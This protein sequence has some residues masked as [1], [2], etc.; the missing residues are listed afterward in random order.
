MKPLKSNK[1]RKSAQGKDCTLRVP[2]ACCFDP[3]YTSLNH[4]TTKK[5]SS[6]GGKVNDTF[7][8]YGCTP[9]HDII[10]RRV[11][12]NFTDGELA[13]YKLDALAETQAIMI[14]EGLIKV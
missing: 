1:L 4:I 2:G 7:A 11:K 14:E 13:I 3:D 12:S 8:V 10:D 6:M 9:C 5:F